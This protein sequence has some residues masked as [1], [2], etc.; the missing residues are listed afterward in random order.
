M[1]GMCSKYNEQPHA[2]EEEPDIKF[3]K[4]S[5]SLEGYY[6]GVEG[7]YNFLKYFQLCEYLLLL[8][9]MRV[10][11]ENPSETRDYFQEVSRQ[12]FLIF[13]ENKIM[14]NFLVYTM[15]NEKEKNADIFK[16]FM[17]D[18]FDSEVGAAIDSF[19]HKNPGVKVYKGQISSVKK[20]NVISIG[21]LYCC[22][23]NSSKMNFFYNLFVN[24]T[25]NFVNS[26]QLEDFLY[27]HF[28]IPA[29]C[30]FRAIKKLGERY[31]EDFTH[32]SN[33]EY[34][35]KNDAFEIK[36][37][38]RLKDI[39]IRDFFKGKERLSKSE[40]TANFTQ[41]DGFGWIFSPSGIRAMLEKNNDVKPQEVIES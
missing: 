10:E 38:Y 41:E 15:L 36:D 19:R 35:K 17:V 9:N 30:A 4:Y 12:D 5:S 8:T 40:F 37:I 18:L 16:D 2:V 28:I 27:F 33:E 14:K 31:P 3:K 29:T 13:I 7:K 6:E 39:F 25:G 11:K 20:L 22:A 26:D 1:G 21:L 24:E 23:K 34:F 32:L